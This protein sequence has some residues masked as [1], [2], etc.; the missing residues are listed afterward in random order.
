[1]LI[2]IFALVL[3]LI[4]LGIIAWIYVFGAVNPIPYLLTAIALLIMGGVALVGHISYL[5]EQ[6]LNA[7]SE[8]ILAKYEGVSVPNTR[9]NK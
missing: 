9:K 8:D 6:Q 5:M 7:E 2:R 4:A 1:M 3:G